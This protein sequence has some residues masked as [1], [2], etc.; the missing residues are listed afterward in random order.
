MRKSSNP[1]PFSVTSEEVSPPVLLRLHSHCQFDV[2]CLFTSSDLSL[3]AL[4]SLQCFFSLRLSWPS[5]CFI[6]H[7]L[8]FICRLSHVCPFFFPDSVVLLSLF[9]SP[10]TLVHLLAFLY[11]YFLFTQQLCSSLPLSPS[12]SLR[13][14]LPLYLSPLS[15]SETSGAKLSVCLALTLFFLPLSK[16]VTTFSVRLLILTKASKW[17]RERE[18]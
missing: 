1:A 3:F 8:S 16:S 7:S 4:L 6:P 2:R 14:L 18:R 12:L 5:T 10:F 17:E 9:S 11:L 15:S 13:L